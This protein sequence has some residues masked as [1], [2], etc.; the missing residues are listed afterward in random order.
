L[1]AAGP[2][3]GAGGNQVFANQERFILLGDERNGFR[4]P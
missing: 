3:A 4:V 1:W 2:A